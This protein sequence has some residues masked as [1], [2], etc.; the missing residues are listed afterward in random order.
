MK[1]LNKFNFRKSMFVGLWGGLLI[2]VSVL[3]DFGGIEFVRSLVGHIPHYDVII[4]FFLVGS[5][6][7][8]V[9][10]V[11]PAEENASK[12]SPPRLVYLLIVLTTLEEC[13]QLFR[14]HRSFSFADMTANTL[15]ILIFYWLG[16]RLK[17]R[18]PF[19]NT[20]TVGSN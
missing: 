18:W 5:L 13:S 7:F 19:T 2:T 17:S 4:H 15:G 11:I 6:G 12:L 9:A 20:K 8:F 14:A 10:L 16:M 3:A 1:E